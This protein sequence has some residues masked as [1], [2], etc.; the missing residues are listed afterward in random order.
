MM[1]CIKCKDT[2]FECLGLISEHPFGTKECVVHK[3]LKYAYK[4]KN[5]GRIKYKMFYPNSVL[6]EVCIYE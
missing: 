1:R 3:C 2:K 4:C 6:K 5:C